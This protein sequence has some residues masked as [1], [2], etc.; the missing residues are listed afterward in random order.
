MVGFA[1][2]M[3]AKPAEW[4]TAAEGW[5]A[6]AREAEEAAED[7]YQRGRQRVVPNWT[8]QV[9]EFAGRRMD[10]LAGS[11]S[12]SAATMRG[13]V[14]ILVGMAESIGSLQQSLLSAVDYGRRNGLVVGADGSVTGEAPPG[15]AEQVVALIGEAVRS[16][17]LVDRQAAAELDRL[18]AAVAN[19][20]RDTAVDDIQQR[21]SE[22][23]LQL[24]REALPI[25]QDPAVVARWWG[26]LTPEQ[27]TEFERAVPVELYDLNGIPEDVKRRLEG[28]D[29]YNRVEMVRW[30]QQN[31]FNTDIDI[32]DNNCANFVSHALAHAGLDQHPDPLTRTGDPGRWFQGLQ[33][34]WDWFDARNFSH[35]PTW[36]LSNAQRDFFLEHG[37]REVPLTQ[38]QPGDVIYWEQAG[39]N[40][41]IEPGR[42]HHAAVVTS[43]TPDG[44]VHYTQHTASRLN[45]SL[46]GRLPT[47]E[48]VEGDQRVVVVRPRQ[49]W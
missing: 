43:V 26:A 41:P 44:N 40:G 3:A 18:A 25:G 9:G 13:V 11:Y 20:D 33:T 28:S 6:L 10:V 31:A 16:A 34:G 32:F 7:V 14:F 12:T 17:D 35:S 46:D 4:S 42:V 2:L 37:G 36:T 45:A 22:A 48:L 5:L 47:N 19:E 15:V 49:T 29:G 23:Q 24:M 39:P 8:D 21:A 30:A 38:A 27:R 1:E